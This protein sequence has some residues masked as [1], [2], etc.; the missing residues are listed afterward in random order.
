MAKIELSVFQRLCLSTRISDE[1]CLQIEVKAHQEER[2][3]RK[4]ALNCQ[5][6]TVDAR[7]KLKRL[8]P[9]YSD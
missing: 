3:A 9:S 7:I 4:A 1:P 8:Y 5:F 6:R 2:N